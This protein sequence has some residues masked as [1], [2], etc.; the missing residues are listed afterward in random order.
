MSF[1]N[2]AASD[3]L[4]RSPAAGSPEP[5]PGP[6]SSSSVPVELCGAPT[7]PDGFFLRPADPE[8]VRRRVA[9]REALSGS[10]GSDPDVWRM[11]PGLVRHMAVVRQE[12][13]LSGF[14][15]RC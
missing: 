2:P 14:L 8:S 13:S 9:V 4:P 3:F 15:E 10:V 7:T 12:G 5:P 6:P 1:L 11:Q